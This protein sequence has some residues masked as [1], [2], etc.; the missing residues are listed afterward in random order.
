MTHS[1]SHLLT[2]IVFSTKNREALLTADIKDRVFAYLAAGLQAHGCLPV[3]I[4]GTTDHVHLLANVH[5][6]TSVAA[7]L[8][9]VKANSSKWIRGLAGKRGFGWQ[10]G[11]GAF[12]VS[13]SNSAVVTRYIQNQEQHHAKVPMID[14]FRSLLIAHRIPFDEAYLLK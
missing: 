10:S 7:L 12:A 1:F 4:N 9:D 3:A 5:R 8:R 14:E 11:Y 6:D 2:H 13:E